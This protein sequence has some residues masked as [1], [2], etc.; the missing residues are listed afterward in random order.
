MN[1]NNNTTKN[2]HINSGMYN[3]IETYNGSYKIV[4][5]LIM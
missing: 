3:K 1:I 5:I 2:S 4:I